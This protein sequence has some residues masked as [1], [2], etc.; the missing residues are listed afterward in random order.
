MSCGVLGVGALALVF[1]LDEGILVS[2]K[3][4]FLLIT[5]IVRFD[6]LL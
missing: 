6:G 5:V 4:S 2:Q 1:L 3:S